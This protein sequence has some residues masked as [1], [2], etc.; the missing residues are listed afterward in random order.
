MLT[1]L[2]AILR[3]PLLRAV[4]LACFLFGAFAASIAPYQS[5]IAIQVLGLSDRAYAAV[6]VS[7]ALVSVTA[8]VA[9]GIL[10]DQGLGRRS[11]ALASAA[12]MVLGSGLVWLMPAPVA[13]ALAHA[14][15]L[16]AAPVFGQV[17][18]MARLAS[19]PHPPERRDAILATVRAIF[20]LPFVVVLPLWSLALA[21]GTGL[22]AIYPALALLAAALW[23]VIRFGWPRSL[24]QDRPS[25]Q[26]F[27]AAL[28]EIGH[29]RVGLRVALLGG[30]TAAITAYMVL[31]GLIFATTPGRSDS[32]VAL[33][34]GLVAGFEVPFMLALPL[35]LRHVSRRTLIALGAAVYG[36]WL[37][38]LPLL[39]PTPFVWA[40]ILPAAA[41]GAA[42]LTL[43]IAYLQDLL[44]DRP[45]AGASLMALQKVAGD[46][47]C[48]AC[49][50]AGT[51]V[52][53]YGLVALMAAALA[54]LGGVGLWW[55]DRRGGFVD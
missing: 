1:A 53:G 16:P 35:V 14:L 23:L 7:A 9:I 31:I 33:F 20:A 48:A 44:A 4:S 11:V 46:A 12:A 36:G 40:L 26:S 54:V 52:S 3:D 6:L 2:A 21:S 10:T 22:L 37:A 41:G 28:R 50:A 5:L 19:L 29:P 18:A 43:P 38:L 47:A 49:F 17:F 24:P 42:V 15:I 55:A 13:F 51:A 45:G 27:A 30:I 39:A 25:G 8:A 32:E 34:V